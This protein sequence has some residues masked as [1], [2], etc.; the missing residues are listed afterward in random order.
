M[1]GLIGALD[2]IEFVE[3]VNIN[4]VAAGLKRTFLSTFL[5]AIVFLCA[6][7]GIIIIQWQES[8]VK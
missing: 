2:T 8:D 6:R 7:V 5:G 1:L 4:I 3:G